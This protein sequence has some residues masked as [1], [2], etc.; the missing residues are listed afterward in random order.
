MAERVQV[1]DLAP[2][3][4]IKLLGMP[5]PFA[6]GYL[7]LGAPPTVDVTGLS[8][9]LTWTAGAI[10]STARDVADF[11]RALLSGQVLRPELLRKMKVMRS[12][13]TNV[14]IPGQQYGL[15]LETF[16]TSCGTA[17]GNNGVVPGYFTFIF[18]SEDGRRHHDAQTLPPTAADKY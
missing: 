15:G 16:P 17:W 12:E 9:S 13:G 18:S 3:E 10:V 5:E 6:H 11:Y 2:A 8:P 1:R 4:G 7:V 14:D